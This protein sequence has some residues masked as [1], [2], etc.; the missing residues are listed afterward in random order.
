MRSF[1]IL[2]AGCSFVILVISHGCR[3]FYFF[4][5][6]FDKNMSVIAVSKSRHWRFVALVSQNELQLES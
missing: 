1:H 4:Q 2:K 6:H 3:N 5:H